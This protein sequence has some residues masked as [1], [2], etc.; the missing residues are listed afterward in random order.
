M[1]VEM[2]SSGNNLKQFEQN[3]IYNFLLV[4][5][6]LIQLLQDVEREKDETKETN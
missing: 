3:E 2:L 1:K 5:L 4:S 6:L